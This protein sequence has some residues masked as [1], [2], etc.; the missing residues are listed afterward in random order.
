MLLSTL[1]PL[2]S[3]VSCKPNFFSILANSTFLSLTSCAGRS[4]LQTFSISCYSAVL[5]VCSSQLSSPLLSLNWD[6]S[7]FNPSC[8][9][10][11]HIEE[12]FNNESFQTAIKFQLRLVFRPTSAPWRHYRVPSC[13]YDR[14][15]WTSYCHW[16]LTLLRSEGRH[17]SICSSW[18]LQICLWSHRFGS[19]WWLGWLNTYLLWVS[20]RRW[21]ICELPISDSYPR[22]VTYRMP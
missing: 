10:A 13:H 14:S 4:L 22:V 19:C 6:L 9:P 21:P 15:G 8:Y 17:Q 3:V 1:F 5:V 20:S 7:Y 11:D 12:L 2:E 18:S 16:V